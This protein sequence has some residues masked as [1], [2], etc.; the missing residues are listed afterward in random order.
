MMC[1]ESEPTSPLARARARVVQGYPPRLKADRKSQDDQLTTHGSLTRCPKLLYP[2][3]CVVLTETVCVL[4]LHE[5]HS[6]QEP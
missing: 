4:S 1:Y 3:S 5:T 6:R 2:L